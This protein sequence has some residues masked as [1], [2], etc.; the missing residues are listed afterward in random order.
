MTVATNSRLKASLWISGTDSFVLLACLVAAGLSSATL[1][2]GYILPTKDLTYHL[3]LVEGYAESL[4]SGTLLPRWFSAAN[5]GLG[6]PTG[7]FIY[8]LFYLFAGSVRMLGLTPWDALRTVCVASVVLSAVIFAWVTRSRLTPALRVL[9]AILLV[10]NP[11]AYWVLNGYNGPG[12]FVAFPFLSLFVLEGLLREPPRVW[13]V[14]VSV[15]LMTLSH[16]LVTFIAL[17]CL[18]AGFVVCAL[19]RGRPVAVSWALRV[20]AGCALGLGVV[21]YYVLPALAST[22][23]VQ[24]NAYFHEGTLDWRNSFA[25][26]VVTSLVYGLYWRAVQ[27]PIAGAYGLGLVLVLLIAWNARHRC[28]AGEHVVVASCAAFGLLSVL[29]ASDAAYPLYDLSATFRTLQRPL[30]MLTVGAVALA[31]AIPFAYE[32][33]RSAGLAGAWRLA[34]HATVLIVTCLFVLMASSVLRAG[35]TFVWSPGLLSAATAQP[36]A[37]PSTA[38][39]EWRQYLARGGFAGE[40]KRVGAR[41]EVLTQR[42]HEKS[43]RIST[44]APVTIVMPLFAFPAWQLSVNGLPEVSRLDP[45]TGLVAV[46]LD[47][48]ISEVRVHW[49]HLSSE[50]V[51]LT[52][53]VATLLLAVAMLIAGRRKTGSRALS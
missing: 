35:N 52:A 5:G 31:L 51:G 14:A 45:G 33:Q 9:G 17:V 7:L 48:G 10:L 2:A 6:D 34:L 1:L 42:P 28:L 8:P 49:T 21:M 44:S 16:I 38:G 26:P 25:L 15:A 11:F 12:W 22:G 30:R 13:V 4:R 40:C 39:A 46:R 24:F 41:C 27:W 3:W 47:P 20:G 53:S 23:L 32:L 50:R 19:T 29:L 18:P 43:W 37:L 36:N